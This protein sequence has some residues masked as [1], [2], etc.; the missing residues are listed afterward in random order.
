MAELSEVK[1]LP[2]IAADWRLER[3][4]GESGGRRWEVVGWQ[5]VV[6]GDTPAARAAGVLPETIRLGRW[7][8][9]KSAVEAIMRQEEQWAA[10]RAREREGAQNGEG[11]GERAVGAQ[12]RDV[13]GFCRGG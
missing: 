6:V 7:V 5:R 13:G 8:A 11:A 1:W 12:S 9:W 3:V 10:E 4:A 2:S